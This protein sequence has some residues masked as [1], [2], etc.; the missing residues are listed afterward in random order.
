MSDIVAVGAAAG[1]VGSSAGQLP[2]LAIVVPLVAAPLCVI[3]RN[4]RLAWWIAFVATASTAL[5]AWRLLGAVDVGGPVRYAVGGWSAPAGIELYVDFLNATVLTL[6]AGISTVAI[7]YARRSIER[8]IE[9]GKR[10][11]FWA[12]WL[13]CLTGL[14]GITIT[15]D[16]FNVFVFLEIS[17]LSTYMLVSFGTDRR[18]LTA[19]FRYVILG[20]VGASFILIGIGFLYAA[21]GTLNMVDLAHRLPAAEGERT[22][23][24][25]FSFLT[26]GLMTKAAIFPLHAWLPNAYQHAPIAATVFLAG[27]ATKVSLYVLV[28]FFDSIFGV[29]YSFGQLF[30]NAIL[31]PAA[32]AGFVIM[33][34]VAVFQTDLRRMLAFS[35]VAQIGYIVAGISLATESGIAAGLVHMVNHGIVK[36]A[37]FMATG[38]ILYRLGHV[39]APSFDDLFRRMPFSCTAFALAGAGLIGIPLT[40]GFV[41]KFALVGAVLERGLWPV[42][43]LIVLSSLLAVVYIGR[44]VE[45]MLFRRTRAPDSHSEGRAEAPASMLLATWFMVAAMFYVGLNGDR[46]L[47]LAQRAAHDVVT[48]LA[49]VP[50]GAAGDADGADGAETHR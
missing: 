7:V 20:S 23:L 22:V 5:I 36:S 21:T 18:A 19:S 40:A 47:E 33:S 4:A 44:V 38:C 37:L 11:L 24:V 26:I 43:A 49:A 41:S 45:I 30:L 48:G 12:A 16:A 34:V 31:L 10:Y 15:G 8:T 1:L 9:T 3:V 14:L 28:R 2:A 42:A 17:S 50:V 29:D 32:V 6:V 25:A 27:T 35:S 46:T 39:H 13:L